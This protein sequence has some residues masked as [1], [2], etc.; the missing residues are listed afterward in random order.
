MAEVTKALPP[1]ESLNDSSTAATIDGN[2]DS[3]APQSANPAGE[4]NGANVEEGGDSQAEAQVDVPQSAASSS[5]TAATA[6]PASQVPD[7]NVQPSPRLAASD[8]TS[9]TSSSRSSPNVDHAQVDKDLGSAEL[10]VGAG[11]EL[12][13]SVPSHQ[14]HLTADGQR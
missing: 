1:T 7:T 14:E 10:D 2:N 8:E 9:S 6:T 3:A 12:E 4:A 11:G 5:A 13:L